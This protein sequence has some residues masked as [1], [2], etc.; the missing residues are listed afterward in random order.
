M[1]VLEY[2]RRGRRGDHRSFPR[3]GGPPISL[4][5]RAQVWAAKGRWRSSTSVCA[6][7]TGGLARA[8][9][10]KPV[11]RSRWFVGGLCRARGKCARG[12]KVDPGRWRAEFRAQGGDV[13]GWVGFIAV[14]HPGPQGC[15]RPHCS[16]LRPPIGSRSAG[17]AG[18][19]C[20]AW[21]GSRGCGAAAK[22]G[23]LAGPGQG[24]K[25]GRRSPIGRD[26]GGTGD[27]SGCCSVRARAWSGRRAWFA[28]QAKSLIQNGP[29]F[30]GIWAVLGSGVEIRSR[31][32]WVG[33]GGSGR[34][35]S[36]VD[37][38]GAPGMAG[39]A[40]VR[41]RRPKGQVGAGPAGRGLGRHPKIGG[42]GSGHGTGGRNTRYRAAGK[43]LVAGV[44]AAG[45]R[46]PCGPGGRCRAGPRAFAAAFASGPC[47]QKAA[48][49]RV[50][51]GGRGS[52]AQGLVTQYRGA[53]G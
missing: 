2:I 38:A 8:G 28:Q 49:V 14:P 27:E 39:A 21:G 50:Q 44:V 37:N 34:K 15:T 5:R 31:S 24:G 46:L 51:G 36:G 7:G 18:R 29:T 12:T 45:G 32:A 25:A 40:L 26:P 43:V 52:W 10:G 42:P 53:S 9:Q 3:V 19:A 35:R 11:P 23:S 48:H 47:A 22:N 1:A 41:R 33:E 20:G 13:G 16:I 30:P 17:G 4:P 6:R